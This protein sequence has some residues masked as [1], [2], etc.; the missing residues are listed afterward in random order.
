[1]MKF[2][3]R[4]KL[5]TDERGFAFTATATVISIILGLTI[6]FMANTVRTE[7]VRTAELYSGQNAYWEAIADVQMAAEMMRLGGVVTVPFLITYF[8]NITIDYLNQINVVITSQV[9]IGSATGGAQRAASINLTSDLYTIVEQGGSP[10]DIEDNV[11]IDGGNIYIGSDIEIHASPL[12]DVGVD[13]MVNIFIPNGSTVN[14]VI[15]EGS[16]NYT[17]TNIASVVM[18]GFDHTAYNVLLNYTG[19]IGADNIPFGEYSG[20][21]TLNN[22]THPGGID[23]QNTNFTGGGNLPLV[24]GG[25]PGYGIFVNGNLTIDGRSG[26]GTTIIDNNTAASPGFIVVDGNITFWG[27]ISAAFTIPDNVVVLT[28]GHVTFKSTDF[29]ESPNYPHNT[30]KNYVNELYTLKGV[31]TTQTTSASYL[32]GQFHIFGVFAHV[33]WASRTSG[34]IYSPNSPYD[35]GSQA[36][37]AR[38]DGNF[39]VKKVK[40]NKFT[41]ALDM[42]LNTHAVLSKALPGGILQSP[43]VSWIILP[44][45]IQEI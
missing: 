28:T 17:V 25:Q 4:A 14:P 18:P 8:P 21:T 26:S 31:S 15:P 5:I 33:G 45:T 29:G 16:N 1:M 30:W 27:S 40:N 2:N 39:N 43:S 34:I 3:Y 35:F 37:G 20:P 11:S 41:A 13:S 24:R 32:F 42:N 44:G 10:F 23:F 12:A 6:L 36:D 7:N 22:S 38:F 9:T 19:T